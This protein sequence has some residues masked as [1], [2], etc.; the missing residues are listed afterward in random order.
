MID[1][2]QPRI[3]LYGHAGCPGTQVAQAYFATRGVAYAYRDIGTD[4]AARAELRAMGEMATPVVLVGDRRLLGFDLGE[5]ER[6][7][8]RAREAE[9]G[10]T[11]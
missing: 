4:P 8:R 1:I 10:W 3:I 11:S 2:E 9:D 5:F 7:C 6:L